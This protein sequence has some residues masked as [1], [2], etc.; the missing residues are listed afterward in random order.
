[1]VKQNSDL[2]T[3]CFS[4]SGLWCQF[5]FTKPVGSP[6]NSK[7]TRLAFSG[8]KLCLWN[9]SVNFNNE[10]LTLHKTCLKMFHEHTRKQSE[11]CKQRKMARV[12]SKWGDKSYCSTVVRDAESQ[13]STTKSCINIQRSLHFWSKK[14]K[15]EYF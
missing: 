14:H 3:W 9:Y 8:C 15:K 10:M 11:I 2:R 12:S 4:N 5:A 1:M 7:N 6:V 13:P